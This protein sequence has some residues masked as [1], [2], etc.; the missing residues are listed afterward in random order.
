MDQQS[1]SGR[2]SLGVA[3]IFHLAFVTIL[4][5]V[6]GRFV[7][8]QRLGIEF[9]RFGRGPEPVKFFGENRCFVHGE[10]NF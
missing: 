7:M 4:A 6:A 9:D 5:Q 8:L 10:F 1:L 2:K 3:G